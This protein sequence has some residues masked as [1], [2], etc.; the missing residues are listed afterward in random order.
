MGSTDAGIIAVLVVVLACLIAFYAMSRLRTKVPSPEAKE[1]QYLETAQR[2]LVDN[3]LWL[4]HYM[5][6]VQKNKA[7]I[8]R[9]EASAA[10]LPRSVVEPAALADFDAA[11]FAIVEEMRREGF[12]QQ[13]V[14]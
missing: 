13:A 9:L 1:K 10:R 8:A 4:E 3:Q 7:R 11:T 2:D 6:E 14:S 12:V 5:F